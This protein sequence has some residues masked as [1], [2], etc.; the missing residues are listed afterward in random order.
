MEKKKNI[1][2]SWRQFQLSTDWQFNISANERIRIGRERE[3]EVS[4]KKTMD[5]NMA[6]VVAQSEPIET[7]GL[8]YR[9][10]VPLVF[11][12]EAAVRPLIFNVADGLRYITFTQRLAPKKS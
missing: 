3:E 10:E 12:A 2:P 1:H 6:L 11:R 5:V 7:R 4:Y 9:G 8:A